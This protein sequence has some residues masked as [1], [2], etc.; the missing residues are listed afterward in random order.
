M[1]VFV[2]GTLMF[3]EVAEPIAGLSEMPEEAVL[4]GYARHTIEDR[5][6]DRVPAI[7]PD[8]DASVAGKLYRDVS[9][10]AIAEIP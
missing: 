9:A 6:W 2:Y 5:E 1:N 3:R 4:R 10:S 7:V 8:T